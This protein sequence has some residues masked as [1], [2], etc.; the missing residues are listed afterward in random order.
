MDFR[1]RVLIVL[2]LGLNL[3][4]GCIGDFVLEFGWVCLM[5]IGDCEWFDFDC[6]GYLWG[7]AFW[8][9]LIVN[10]WY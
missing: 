6:Y 9:L 2:V 10:L 5:S 8:V 3:R 4:F 1:G 7:L